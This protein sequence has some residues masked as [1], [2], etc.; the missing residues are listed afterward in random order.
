MYP[1]EGIHIQI[2]KALGSI[3][4]HNAEKKLECHDQR[5]KGQIVERQFVQQYQCAR[6]KGI[7]D[8]GEGNLL[9]DCEWHHGVASF[10]G[11]PFPLI[12]VLKYFNKFRSESIAAVQKQFC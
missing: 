4:S 12:G 1:L 6:T 10:R 8:D 7:G 9:L 5:W 2:S 3:N 11:L